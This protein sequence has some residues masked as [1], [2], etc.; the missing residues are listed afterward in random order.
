[1]PPKKAAKKSAKHQDDKHH[2]AK[3][4]R[5]AYEHLGRVEILRHVLSASGDDIATLVDLAQREVANGAAKNAADLLRAAEH[6][7]FAAIL[8]RPSGKAEVFGGLM[9]AIR[10][11]F[12]RLQEKAQDH[13]EADG[14]DP[15]VGKIF[16]DSLKKAAM[17]REQGAYRQALELVRGAEALAHVKTGDKK[18]EPKKKAPKKIAASS[19][20]RELAAS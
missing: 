4:L 13:W 6:L 16:K 3:D 9:S 18:H 10:D 19:N 2:H 20:V 17:A 12:D 1:M 8:N 15:A 14:A 11:E 5:R 7:G